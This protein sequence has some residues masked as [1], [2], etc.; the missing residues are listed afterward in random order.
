M[1]TYFPVGLQAAL[2][3]PGCPP[4]S[5]TADRRIRALF[6]IPQVDPPPLHTPAQPLQMYRRENYFRVVPVCLCV[7]CTLGVKGGGGMY[8][9]SASLKGGV[10]DPNT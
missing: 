7:V 9:F 10:P 4:P 8:G 1:F 5:R 2:G 3:G 6:Q